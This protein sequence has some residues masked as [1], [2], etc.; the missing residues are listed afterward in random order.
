MS[1]SGN[2]RADTPAWSCTSVRQLLADVRAYET[3]QNRDKQGSYGEKGGSVGGC[4]RGKVEHPQC[5]AGN[6]R[7]DT[8]AWSCTSVRQLLA[9]VRAYETL[10]NRDKQGSYGEKGGGVGGCSRGK[11]VRQLLADVRAYETLQNRDKQGSYGEK[12]GSVGGCSRGKVEHPQ[13]F[14]NIRTKMTALRRPDGTVTSSRTIMEVIHDFYF[15]LFDSH[16]F[17]LAISLVKKRTS[18]GPKTIRPEHVKNPPPV[19][20]N[21]PLLFLRYLS[22]CK[23]PSQ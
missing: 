12:G 10:Q 4:S 14:A 6:S 11:V 20:T 9:D 7:A 23:V 3:L 16:V 15:D 13:C 5:F 21:T 17:R 22:E 8:P 1:V 18:P 19:L 2:S